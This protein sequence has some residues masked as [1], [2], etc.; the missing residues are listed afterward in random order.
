MYRSG[1]GLS[2]PCDR[3]TYVTHPIDIFQS[4]PAALNALRVHA[5][6]GR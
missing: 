2:H 3:D 4:T 6:P 5:R 1:R